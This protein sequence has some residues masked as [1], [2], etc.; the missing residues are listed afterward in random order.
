MPRTTSTLSEDLGR[1]DTN[2]VLDSEVVATY[3]HCGME[4][5]SLILQ[6]FMKSFRLGT[7]DVGRHR[8]SGCEIMV[9]MNC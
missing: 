6:Q 4:K 8:C 3:A 1:N 5:F 9:E 2:A 7:R